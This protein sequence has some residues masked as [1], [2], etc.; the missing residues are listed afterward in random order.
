MGIWL[1]IFLKMIISDL[2]TSLRLIGPDFRFTCF[3]IVVG[4]V[5]LGGLDGV[6]IWEISSLTSGNSDLEIGWVLTLLSF[7]FGLKVFLLHREL[8]F[9]KAAS[10]QL[11][12]KLVSNY[13]NTK[14]DPAVD[15]Q[16]VVSDLL[17][18]LPNIPNY[19]LQAVVTGLTCCAILLVYFVLLTIFL[20]IQVLWVLVG[21][22][23]LLG[24]VAAMLLGKAGQTGGMVSSAQN[25]VTSVAEAI[26]DSKCSVIASDQG[27][28]LIAKFSRAFGSLLDLQ[29]T[30][31]LRSLLPKYFLEF[32]SLLA[33]VTIA[34]WGN[35]EVIV[36]LG[37]TGFILYRAL[38]YASS[39]ASAS[40]TMRGYLSSTVGA[41][42]ASEERLA[43]YEVTRPKVTLQKLSKGEI[44]FNG[45]KTVFQNQGS[46][47]VSLV[48]KRGEKIHLG[49]ISG[50]GK[51][52][53]LKAIIGVVPLSEGSI[54]IVNEHSDYSIEYVDQLPF[55][56]EGTLLENLLLG[57]ESSEG[58]TAEAESY[59]LK[60]GLQQKLDSFIQPD[61]LSGGERQ[62][63]A[64]LRALLAK[65]DLLLLD[66]STSAMNK[67]L[68]S[69]IFDELE[70]FE[71]A[72][73]MVSHSTNLPESFKKVLLQ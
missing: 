38:P 8:A 68:A 3:F 42:V 64:V 7:G 45:V 50:I 53:L 67:E 6:L 28:F 59:L 32:I 58:F 54:E 5:V 40:I 36:D 14:N 39:L 62:R 52:S 61:T 26:F 23:L 43:T 37:I 18:R 10:I 46:R 71:G 9:R 16:K 33:V 1:D 49:G 56:F 31:G 30:I 55:V 24:G 41:I 72:I 60:L 34:V 27:G 70:Y 25:R 13:L 35:G 17:Q 12:L 19:V 44:H 4:Y 47:P 20:P 63:V 73:I 57:K 29:L 48:V 66:E 65:P 21:A 51:S 2:F 15:G 22:A 69:K 11:G